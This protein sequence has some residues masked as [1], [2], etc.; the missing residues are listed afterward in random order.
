MSNQ[1]LYYRGLYGFL[2]GSGIPTDLAAVKQKVSEVAA[3]TA[4]YG[5]QA[6]YH[7]VIDEGEA[8]VLVAQIPVWEAIHTAGGKVNAGVATTMPRLLTW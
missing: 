4:P 6:V 5:T 2:W 7:Y 1:T 8:E 3:F